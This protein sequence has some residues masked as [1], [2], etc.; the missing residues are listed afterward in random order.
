ME[1]YDLIKMQ[2]TVNAYH[3]SDYAN[4]LNATVNVQKAM[5]F[6]NKIGFFLN[7]HPTVIIA[8]LLYAEHTA[9]PPKAFTEFFNAESLITSIVPTTNG[10]VQTIVPELD[11]VGQDVGPARYLPQLFVLSRFISLHVNITAR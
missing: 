6:D 11:T 9:Q 7:V 1:V 10:T 5:E 3:A 2:Y 8:G 4:L